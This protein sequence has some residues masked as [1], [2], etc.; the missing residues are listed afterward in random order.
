MVSNLSPAPLFYLSKR[1]KRC[2]TCSKQIIKPNVQPL[3]TEPLKWNAI[4]VNF[5]TKVTIYQ[6]PRFKPGATT[7]D[8]YLQF[9]N[10]NFNKATIQFYPLLESQSAGKGLNSKIDLPVGQMMIDPIEQYTSSGQSVADS[11]STNVKA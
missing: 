2:K 10:P 7:Y 6:V 1:V 5:I 4:L 9:R 3:S 8:L 11:A